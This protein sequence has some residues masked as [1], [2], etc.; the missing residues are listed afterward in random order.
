M[1]HTRA[2][3]VQM[4]YSWRVLVPVLQQILPQAWVSEGAVLV[5]A[6]TASSSSFSLAAC[7]LAF[8]LGRTRR[9]NGRPFAQFLK[10]IHSKKNKLHMKITKSAGKADLLTGTNLC[11]YTYTYYMYIY[12]MYNKQIL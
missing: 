1:A 2:R 8:S 4:D 5:R 7:E 11:I 9:A 6:L 3:Q 10:R 12:I